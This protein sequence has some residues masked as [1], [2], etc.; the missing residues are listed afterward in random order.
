MKDLIAKINA[1]IENFKTESESL[2][3]KGVKAAGARARKSSL[4]IEKLLKE[5]R[6]VSIEES[7]K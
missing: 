3:E 7:K 6:K 2:A 4:E 5:F 1:E